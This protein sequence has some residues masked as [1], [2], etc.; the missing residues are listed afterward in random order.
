MSKLEES[1]DNLYVNISLINN[2]TIRDKSF[3]D[4][5]IIRKVLF[6][7]KDLLIVDKDDYDGEAKNDYWLKTIFGH[8]VKHLTR[9]EYEI[10]KE[11]LEDD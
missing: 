1:L 11:V 6:S 8:Y 7:I 2:E 3:E 9:E 10:W 5:E 4:L